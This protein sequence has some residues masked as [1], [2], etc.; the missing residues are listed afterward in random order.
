MLHAR[1]LGP[2][3][4][5]AVVAAVVLLSFVAIQPAGATLIIVP[6]ASDSPPVVSAP[7]SIPNH[8]FQSPD[9]A[10]GQAVFTSD[11][12][13]AIAN[14][15]F[16]G[17]NN[18]LISGGVWDPAAADYTIAGGNNTALPPSADG[19]QAAFIYLD[20]DANPTPQLMSGDLTTAAAVATVQS[21]FSYNLTVAL[22]RAKGVIT[23]EVEVQLLISKFPIASLVVTPAQI[24]QDD[25][26][27]FTVNLTTF[28]DYPF[29]G[30]ELH[31]RITHRYGGLGAA[32]VDIDNVRLDMT[33]VPEP[34]GAAALAVLALGATVT[35]R[36]NRN[37]PVE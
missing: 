8:T 11:N 5:V 3:P 21:D 33:R 35:R 10:D 2:A 16:V 30:E 1:R 36:R 34:T 4:V 32:S 18:G 13:N 22:G 9:V 27:D 19:G 24:P 14:W 37:R 28:E 7:V 23:G 29:A 31:A 17:S 20:Q 12:P 26:A 15:T 25:F 6:N